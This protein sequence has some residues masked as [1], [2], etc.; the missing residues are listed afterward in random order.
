[1]GYNNWNLVFMHLIDI[2]AVIILLGVL[3]FIHELGHYLVAKWCGVRVETFSIGFGKRLFGFRRGDTDYRVSLIPLG[4]YVKMA[5]ENPMESRTGD[6]GEFASHPRWQRFLIAL[7][8]P[9]MNIILAL[10]LYTAIYT[11]HHQ[12]SAYDKAPVDIFFFTGDSP[13]QKAGLQAGDRIIKIEDTQNPTWDQA[14]MSFALNPKQPVDVTVRRGERILSFKVTPDEVG[15]DKIGDA[16]IR[17][18]A[19][20]GSVQAGSPA[21][22]AGLQAGDILLAVNSTS[23]HGT[24]DILNVLQQTKDNPVSLTV[25]RDGSEMHLTALPQLLDGGSQGKKYRL[26][27]TN[28]GVD[29]LPVSVAFNAAYQQCKTNSLLVFKLL[30][31]LIASKNSIKQMSGP[32]G[33]AKLS[34]DAAMQGF[35]TY[36]EAMAF[37]SLNLAVLNLLPIPILDGGLMLMLLIEGTI[38]RDI[39]LRFKERMYQVAFVALV[40]FFSVV[41]FNDVVKNFVHHV[42]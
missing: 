22:R 12:Y 30:S 39:S 6:P 8:G 33:I 14:V 24:D 26:G 11:F 18:P 16:G 25:W 40:L 32:V 1:L 27:F 17:A 37:I 29:R 13:A 3:V 15:P 34:G 35:A 10:G 4:G 41:I 38:R 7:A 2:P 21:E 28:G 19:I 31:K 20:I 36:M 5:G 23:V 9:A 42:R